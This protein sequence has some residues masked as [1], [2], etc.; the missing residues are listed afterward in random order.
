[1][2]PIWQVITLVVLIVVISSVVT[3]FILSRG[4]YIG[5]IVIMKEEGGKQTISLQLNEDPAELEHLNRVIFK[6][7]AQKGED[8][9]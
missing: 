3:R 7:T 6:V 4:I 5:D 2:V 8:Y 9:E 1:M